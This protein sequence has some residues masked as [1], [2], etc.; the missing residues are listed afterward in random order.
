MELKKTATRVPFN[1]IASYGYKN[2]TRYTDQKLKDSLRPR[3]TNVRSYEEFVLEESQGVTPF[4]THTSSGLSDYVSK[5]GICPPEK[6]EV[7]D[8]ALDVHL[9]RLSLPGEGF[10]FQFSSY[11][12]PLLVEAELKKKPRKDKMERIKFHS[13]FN[14]GGN[15]E[16]SKKEVF[17]TETEYYGPHVLITLKAPAVVTFSFDVKWNLYFPQQSKINL[18]EIDE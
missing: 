16:R 11:V 4:F 14:K 13:Y 17:G 10:Q 5:L 1:S 8:C 3:W 6:V 12:H 7:Y 15:F 9:Q 2:L 18:E